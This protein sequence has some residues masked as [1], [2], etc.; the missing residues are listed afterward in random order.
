[1]FSGDIQ[2]R[3]IQ[4]FT[5]PIK[6]RRHSSLVIGEYGEF[7]SE[8]SEKC[9]SLTIIMMCIYFYFLGFK[10]I[11][12]LAVDISLNAC[13]IRSLQQHKYCS[14]VL[15]L[16]CLLS[17]FKKLKLNDRYV[18]GTRSKIQFTVVKLK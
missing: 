2:L 8:S 18:L 14:N 13:N 15:I 9:V 5:A 6:I 16:I 17:Q 10:V 1:M 4:R 11:S 3:R 7:Y 12:C